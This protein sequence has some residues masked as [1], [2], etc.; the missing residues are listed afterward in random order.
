M[1]PAKALPFRQCADIHRTERFICVLP[2]SGYRMIQPE[3]N[4]YVIYLA[5]DA[6]DEALGGALLEALERSRFIPPPN[7]PEFFK[8]ERYTQC[9]SNWERDFMG[10]YGYNTKRDAYKNM[11]WSRAKRFEGK[12]SITPHKRDKPGYFRSLPP[13]R[14]VVIPATTEPLTAGAALRLALDRCE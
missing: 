9:H 11:D 14:S 3:D 6:G 10:R 13:E 1:K 4:G 7:E 8:W 5:S 12:I 2:L